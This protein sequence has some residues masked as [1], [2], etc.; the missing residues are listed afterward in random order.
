MP[1]RPDMPC[2]GCG[3]LMW[4]GTGTLPEG[5]ARCRSCR[6]QDLREVRHG[7]RQGYRQRRCRC[8]E[9]KAWNREHQRD[10]VWQ[11]KA[12][13]GVS[14]TQKYRPREPGYPCPD[15]GK[16]I[17]RGATCKTCYRSRYDRERRAKAKR[18][19]ASRRLD[20]AAEGTAGSR[21][22]VAGDCAQCG[23]YFARRGAV[24][25]YCSSA[26]SRKARPTRRQF[27]ISTRD[28]LAIY[29]RDQWCCQLC[30]EPVERDLM[31]IDP[32]ND[33]APS[34][35][36]IEPQSHALIPD[37]SAGNL[38][39]AHRWCNSVRGDLTYYTDADLRAA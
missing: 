17:F 6:S 21:T 16:R 32:L 35:D 14:P 34:L 30:L 19:G 8:D 10:Y 23:A 11:V 38:R 3:A 39:L 2:A 26:C 33:W 12:R 36:H 18:D 9:C 27:R 15:C 1:R 24:S 29:D 25:P 28:R 37:H 4:R 13:D 5:Q 22:W 7:T 31:T 20:R